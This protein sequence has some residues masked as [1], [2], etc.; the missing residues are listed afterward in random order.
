MN[1]RRKLENFDLVDKSSL[2]LL[3]IIESLINEFRSSS[4][5]S[6]ILSRLAKSYEALRL[7]LNESI[8]HETIK[9]SGFYLSKLLV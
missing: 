4:S 2:Q 6:T 7:T 5:K 8:L 1:K 9:S 3:D